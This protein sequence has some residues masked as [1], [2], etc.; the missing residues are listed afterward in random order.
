M[1]S[2][3][4][5]ANKFEKRTRKVGAYGERLTTQRSA[6]NKL[7]ANRAHLQSVAE[8]MSKT[9]KDIQSLQQTQERLKA[10]YIAKYRQYKKNARRVLGNNKSLLSR[11]LAS[12]HKNMNKKNTVLHNVSNKA[13]GANNTGA[14]PKVNLNKMVAN[15][16]RGIPPKTKSAWNY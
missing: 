5:P 1:F 6:I 16:A 2:F 10:E 4:R 11:A 14:R 3:L 9:K 8:G 13:V 12:R 7:D 15:A